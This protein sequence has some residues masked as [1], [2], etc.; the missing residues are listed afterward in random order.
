MPANYDTV[1]D[2]IYRFAIDV[3]EWQPPE[4][5]GDKPWFRSA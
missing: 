5:P 1:R 2:Y 3:E 4:R